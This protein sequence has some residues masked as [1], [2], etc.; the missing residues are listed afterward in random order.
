[1]ALL[2]NT[3]AMDAYHSSHLADGFQSSPVTVNAGDVESLL[4]N[5]DLDDLVNWLPEVQEA[6][7]HDDTTEVPGQ[8]MFKHW[9]S[10]PNM[11]EAGPAMA[12]QEGIAPEA[13]NG[14][15]EHDVVHLQ[16]QIDELKATLS[17]M[18][19][20]GQV[21]TAPESGNVIAAVPASVPRRRHARTLSTNIRG[22]FSMNPSGN[23]TPSFRSGFSTPAEGLESPFDYP[24]DSPIYSRRSSVQSN[25]SAPGKRGQRIPGGY[26][27]SQCASNFDLPSKLRH[28]ERKHIAK[29]QRRHGC[30]ECGSR[31]LY[32]KDLARHERNVHK[33]DNSESAVGQDISA[34]GQSTSNTDQLYVGA[35]DV[36]DMHFANTQQSRKRHWEQCQ[37]VVRARSRDRR[38]T[39]DSNTSS[40]LATDM[41]D[42]TWPEDVA[43]DIRR[44]SI[45]PDIVTEDMDKPTVETTDYDTSQ[46]VAELLERVQDQDN[47]IRSLQQSHERYEDML[48]QSTAPRLLSATD[49]PHTLTPRFES[50]LA[51]KRWLGSIYALLESVPSLENERSAR[52]AAMR[53]LDRHLDALN[54]EGD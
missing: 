52:V 48:Q 34:H 24:D 13:S 14:N 17:T 25:I 51:A 35:M 41:P 47:T 43:P 54:L 19:E 29:D 22:S 53:M 50:V 16:R 5:N 9:L 4:W 39:N 6:S 31:F 18:A 7:N 32:P 15:E 30:N 20:K 11:W 27:C 21:A 45:I 42:V 37:A 46:T 1:M 40:S 44:D 23:G 3:V 36:A 49:Q 26:R 33:L 28:H 38:L 12:Q 8:A 10:A 2:A